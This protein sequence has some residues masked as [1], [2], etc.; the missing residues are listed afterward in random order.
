MAHPP[1]DDVQRAR[2]VR[3]WRLRSR[4]WTQGRIG[5]ELGITQGAISKLLARV[6]A[7]ESRRMAKR[8]G[9]VKVVQSAVLDHITEEAI[10]AWHRSKAPR[11]RA[12]SKRSMPGGDGDAGDAGDEVQTTEVVERDG[13]TGYLYAAMTAMGHQRSLWG[14]DVAP[15]LQDPAASVSELVR[16]FVGRGA[17]YEQRR[18]GRAEDGKAG[19]PARTD[20]ADPRGIGEV[21]DGPVTVQ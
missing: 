4:G 19:D 18:A 16:D 14:L 7:R 10:D 11:K 17:T 12:A 3:A 5:D 13:D 15:A 1:P 8:S 2:E 21:P 6:E 20:P 9:R